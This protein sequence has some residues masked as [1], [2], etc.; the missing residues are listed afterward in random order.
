M[1]RTNNRILNETKTFPFIELLPIILEILISQDLHKHQVYFCLKI[2]QNLFN[3]E[4]TVKNIEIPL[5]KIY[6]KYLEYYTDSSFM[7]EVFKKY[8]NYII[9][10]PR[11]IFEYYGAL[12]FLNY[13]KKISQSKYVEIIFKINSLEPQN[14]FEKRIKMYI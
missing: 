3:L 1:E 12:K 11:T 9:N 8:M 6:F 13:T 14:E 10:E 2:L 5:K 7:C 4:Y